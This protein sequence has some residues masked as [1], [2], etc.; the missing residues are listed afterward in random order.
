[1]TALLRGKNSKDLQLRK[2]SISEITDILD[3]CP[4]GILLAKKGVIHFANQLLLKMI[5]YDDLTDILGKH[6]QDVVV[7]IDDI[8]VGDT[9][10]ELASE[11]NQQRI[12]LRK[13]NETQIEV[14]ATTQMVEIAKDPVLILYFEESVQ[15]EDATEALFTSQERFKRIFNQDPYYAYLVSTD[16][17]ILDINDCAVRMLGYEKDEI[18]GQ[19]FLNLYAQ[20]SKARASMLFK[21]W[22]QTGEINNEE[23]VLL[24]RS[25]EKRI[26]LLSAGAVRD[27]EGTIIHSISVQQDITEQKRIERILHESEERYRMI[28]STSGTAMMIAE[29]FGKI[30]LVN[31]ELERLLGFPKIELEGKKSWMEFTDDRNAERI[32]YESQLL[33]VTTSG[34]PRK[35]QVQMHDKNGSL[36]N[37]II[38]I[39]LMPGSTN[40]VICLTEITDQVSI[41]EDLRSSEERYRTLFDSASD[42]ILIH[43]LN[44]RF[45]EVNMVACERLGYTRKEFLELKVADID[46]PEFSS[47]VEERIREIGVNKHILFQ[48]EHVTKEGKI[49]PTEINSRLITY[50]GVQAILSIAR[51]VSLKKQA[52]AVLNRRLEEQTVLHEVAMAGAATTSLDNL[53]ERATRAIGSL[54][55]PDNF[56][57]AF[58]DDETGEVRLHAS[59]R[60][61]GTEERSKPIPPGIG[62]TGR[63]IATGQPCRIGD[64]SFD[65][66]FV[67][68]GT[69][70]IKSELCVPLK[71]GDRIVG[72]VNAENRRPNAFDEDDERIIIILT[73]QISIAMEKIRSVQAERRRIEELEALRATMKDI[74]GELELD[75]LLSKIVERAAS[76]MNADCWALGL[77]D[78]ARSRIRIVTSRNVRV[79]RD[80]PELELGEGALG[81]AADTG[82]PL[83]I[84]D[85]QTWDGRSPTLEKHSWH[86]TMASPLLSG[87]DLVG[88]IALADSR[89]NRR[90]TPA[91]IRLLTMFAQQ[92]AIA[93]QNARLFNDVQQ[94]AITDPLTGLYNRRHFFE[95][96]KREVSRALRMNVPLSL[97]MLDV[98]YFKKVNDTFGHGIGDSVLC[99]IA[100]MCSNR[101]RAVDLLGR[102]GGDEYIF[103]LPETDAEGARV[104]GNDLL[105]SIEQAS[106]ENDEQVVHVTISIGISTLSSSVPNLER[107]LIRADEALYRA[108]EGGRNR[109]M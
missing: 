69:E 38:S 84:R 1:M 101:L 55:F 70:E 24:T 87:H 93:V 34:S 49:V 5:H 64:V 59:Y 94:L 31:N 2:I 63:V 12:H 74:L 40:R 39:A 102:Y 3:S 103:V 17:T 98:D 88:A 90:F 45:I 71:V 96:A 92:A 62:V 52:D 95:L 58:I 75:K 15:T 106:I 68:L 7:E 57:F 6:L 53:I 97:L 32:W 105:K 42:A 109:V 35:T 18:I 37:L 100:D 21:R 50:G 89:K 79:N 11:P 60:G 13:S 10:S 30:I 28:F 23:L 72:V 66:V 44:G 85:Y 51:D 36:K 19:R 61:V 83:L 86:A 25:G 14:F 29:A 104:V 4:Y 27:S 73:G 33:D 8:V 56:G 77:F 78:E 65:P 54:L 76:L 80:S 26:V 108:K 46:S 47:L 91:N 81:R 16:G 43:D 41:L 20:E 99:T 67:P 48:T 9:F 22:K 107:L 82:Q